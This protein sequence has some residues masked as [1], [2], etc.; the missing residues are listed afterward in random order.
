MDLTRL[1]GGENTMKITHDSKYES[2][3]KT[4]SAI[5]KAVFVNFYYDFK[6]SSLS[7]EELA[8]RIYE[9][10]PGSVSGKQSYRIPRA[11]HIFDEGQNLDAL[12]IIISSERV[13]PAAR[14]KAKVIL[15]DEERIAENNRTAVLTYSDLKQMNGKPV[16]VTGKGRY[17]F[18]AWYLVDC[19]NNAV[20]LYNT[21]GILKVGSDD[22]SI[23]IWSSEPTDH[24]LNDQ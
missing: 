19:D 4:L 24:E 13:D 5:G 6:D 1:Y 11:R 22:E 9:K 20:T 16:F 8:T 7:D 2:I 3:N 17:I 10:N 14:Q 23:V 12:R 15:H 18:K 21:S